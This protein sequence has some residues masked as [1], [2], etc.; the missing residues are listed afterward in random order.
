MWIKPSSAME[1]ERQQNGVPGSCVNNPSSGTLH[2]MGHPRCARPACR[3]H[4]LRRAPC[5]QHPNSTRPVHIQKNSGAFRLPSCKFLVA[6]G[7]IRTND[8]RVMRGLE[9]AKKKDYVSE[10]VFCANPITQTTAYLDRFSRSSAALP[11]RLRASVS[12][13]FLRTFSR[14]EQ[15]DHSVSTE[16]RATHM[17]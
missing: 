2:P 10:L 12:T 14:F 3:T 4:H 8:L 5:P 9:G 16:T 11:H 6:E 7:R 15:P 1:Q 17:R 13:E